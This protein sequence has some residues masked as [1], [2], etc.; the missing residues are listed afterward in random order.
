MLEK[1][2]HGLAPWSAYLIVPVFGFANAG[3]SL[4][5]LGLEALFDPLP[6]A[7]AAGLVIG[8]Q[9]GIFTAVWVSVKTGFAQKPDHASWAEIY[10]VAVL[11][12]DDPNVRAMC[13]RPKNKIQGTLYNAQHHFGK[14]A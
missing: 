5:G 2:E 4:Q 12:A 13:K 7:I 9:L 6:Y 11:C 8:K 10:G 1:L 3:V 14:R